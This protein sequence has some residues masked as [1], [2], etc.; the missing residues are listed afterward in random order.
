[1]C[2]FTVIQAAMPKLQICHS[3]EMETV[4]RITVANGVTLP[5]I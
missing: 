2:K 5:Q 1:M 4:N 3:G